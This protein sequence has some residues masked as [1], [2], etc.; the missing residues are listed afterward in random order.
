MSHLLTQKDQKEQSYRILVTIS[1]L[2]TFLFKKFSTREKYAK[3]FDAG[4]EHEPTKNIRPL[5]QKHE[6]SASQKAQ[7]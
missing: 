7:G 6:C 1:N 4:L 2:R 3:S 5:V